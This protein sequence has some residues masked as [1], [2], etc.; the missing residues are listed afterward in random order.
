MLQYNC[1][2]M[3]QSIV[4]C[5]GEYFEYFWC[6]MIILSPALHA[7]TWELEKNINILNE[8][9]ARFLYSKPNNVHVSEVSIGHVT[10]VT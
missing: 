4:A 8:N 2:T 9:A 5:V 1:F 3:Q 6:E 7:A 10:N